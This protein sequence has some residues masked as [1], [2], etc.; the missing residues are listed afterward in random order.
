M[1]VVSIKSGTNLYG[2]TQGK[3]ATGNGLD[4]VSV[5]DRDKLGGEDLGAILNKVAD[6]N[7]VDPSK[8]MRTVGKSELD[9]DAFFKLMLAQMKNQ[10]PTNPMKSHEMAAQLASFSSLEQMQ[11]INTT[12]TEMRGAQKPT[13]NF[14]ALN[15]IGKAVM[16]DSSQIIRTRQDKEH[17]VHFELPT[18]AD[19][20]IRIRNADGAV[21]RTYDL[22]GLKKGA[23]K[24]NWNGED[25][26]GVKLPEGE[27]QA[28]I[29][30]KT[31]EGQKIA[32]K[33]DFE[34]IITGVNFTKEG[35]VLLVGNQTVVMRDVKKITDASLMKN[36]QKVV[37][38][39]SQDLKKVDEKNENNKKGIKNNGK[40]EP[41][42]A[43]SNS[44]TPPL[45]AQG[46][47]K[48]FSSVGMSREML[49]R[50]A[51]ETK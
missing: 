35:P 2:E 23:N 1:G 41:A 30:G 13:E 49:N 36:D 8:K 6:A 43:S 40:N 15:L 14:Q 17:E 38:A 12:L 26:G 46:T 21:V 37:D 33:T 51:K 4:N 22:K 39:T 27:Y 47:N 19:I 29:E 28:L 42:T 34:G 45:P 5:T 11:N 16:G 50:L 10:D 25:S 24:I 48:L 20:T 3:K 7:W 31:K 9:K 44:S 18:E 32:V